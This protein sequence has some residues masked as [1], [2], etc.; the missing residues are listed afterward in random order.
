MDPTNVKVILFDYD[1]TLRDSM[2]PGVPGTKPSAFSRAVV[3]FQPSLVGQEDVIKQLYFETSGKNRIWQLHFVEERLRVTSSVPASEEKAWSD[4][5]NS[6]IDERGMPLFLGAKET[7]S[8]LSDC[9]YIVGIGS[10]VPQ[11]HL[12]VII[13]YHPGLVERLDFM[14]GNR[15][16]SKAEGIEA[17]FVKGIAYFSF[18]MGKYNVQPH[19]IALVGD[20]PKDMEAGYGAGAFTIGKVDTRIPGRREIL[21]QGQPDLL[22]DDLSELLDVFPRR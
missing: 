5:F 20:A 16:L 13:N 8:S 19:E 3:D 6:Y 18:I 7:V 17:N 11:E 22:I 15:S 12:E 4:K 21:A 1:G 10:S 2:N 14:L 9:R